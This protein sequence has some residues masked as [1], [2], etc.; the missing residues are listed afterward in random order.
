MNKKYTLLIVDDDK[1][2]RKNLALYFEENSYICSVAES[3][4]IALQILETKKFDLVISDFFMEGI[5]GLEFLKEIKKIFPKLPVILMTGYSNKQ[6]ISDAL[7]NG[8]VNFFEKPFSF[9]D[10]LSYSDTLLALISKEDNYYHDLSNVFIEMKRKMVVKSREKL[11]DIVP[12]FIFHEL[13]ELGYL[14]EEETYPLN[15][16]LIEAL[17]NALYH[18]N[19]AISSDVRNKGSFADQTKFKKLIRE[20]EKDPNFGNKKIIIEY[21]CVKEFFTCSIQDEG[22]G[23]NHSDYKP[24][25][26]N[27]SSGKGL[28]LIKAFVDDISF[29]AKGNKVQIT[30]YLNK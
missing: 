7:Q 15:T 28:F 6:L 16:A 12:K 20:K 10:I 2:I 23:F 1:F 17:S 30:K 3:A 5:N 8:A 13:I 26:K 11:I 21:R 19:F 27:M 9:F 14:T 25:L 24:D 22:E 4:E 18:G 29:N